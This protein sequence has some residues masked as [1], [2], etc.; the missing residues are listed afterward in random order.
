[1]NLHNYNIHVVSVTTSGQQLQSLIFVYNSYMP[2]I[3]QMKASYQIPL[4]VAFKHTFAEPLKFTLEDVLKLS[5]LS[6]YSNFPLQNT[7]FIF[8]RLSIHLSGVHFGMSQYSEYIA[9][10]DFSR[11]TPI[12]LLG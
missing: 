11:N 5:K 10:H 12:Y 4:N 8:S 1:M 6:Y 3:L 9:R 7:E 2:Q